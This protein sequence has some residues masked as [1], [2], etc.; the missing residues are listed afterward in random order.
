MIRILAISVLPICLLMTAAAAPGQ[1]D[2][3]TSTVG[4]ATTLTLLSYNVLANDLEQRVDAY[5]AWIAEQKPDIA[6]IQELYTEPNYERM[7]EQLAANG[8]PMDSR[9]AIRYMGVF[10]RLPIHDYE[11]HPDGYDR[12]VQTFVIDHPV[13]GPTRIFQIHPYPGHACTV[14]PQLLKVASQ[15][16]EP[17]FF[18]GDFNLEARGECFPPIIEGHEQACT[19][20]A[21]PS[22]ANTVNREV[23]CRYNPQACEG[24]TFGD[25]A[26]DHIFRQKTAPWRLEKAWCDH[27]M[28]L[29][30][31]FPVLARYVYQPVEEPP[32]E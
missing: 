4:A 2:S 12:K 26:I 10:S 25:A 1:V 6:C 23:W 11:E 7:K 3:A 22:C 21:D 17:H 20:E 5:A 24:R 28:K 16:S 30:D 29:S 15:Y 18:L 9:Q 8:W 31:H 14:V 27:D 32:S 19:P 13:A